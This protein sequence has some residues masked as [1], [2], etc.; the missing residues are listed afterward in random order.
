M[1]VW[2]TCCYL[3]GN[4]WA[5]HLFVAIKSHNFPS[6][7]HNRFGFFKLGYLNYTFL[8]YTYYD[9]NFNL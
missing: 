5:T 4:L 8:D 9:L 6:L 1:A 2:R 7:L 3:C